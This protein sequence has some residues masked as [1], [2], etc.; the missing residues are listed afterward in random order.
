[1]DN[2]NNNAKEKKFQDALVD[3]K[4]FL[5][6]II[7]DFCQNL[8]EEEMEDHLGAKKYE[9]TY[10]RSGHRN[11][12]KPRMLKT[13]VGTL[14]LLVPQDRDGNFSTDL[15]N[16]Y[17]RSEKALV[18]TLM[19]MY[20]KGISTRK[21]ADVTEKLCGTSFSSSTIS[22]LAS[23]LDAKI[24][25]WNGRPLN[26]AYP[27][28]LVDT[29]YIKSRIED[30]V[31]AQ[32]AAVVAAIDSDGY[33]EILAVEMIDTETAQSYERIFKTLKARGLTGVKLVI[34]DDNRG[35]V[36]AVKK[37]FLGAFW[38]RC[39]F[40]FISNVVDLVPRKK[41]KYLAEDLKA[42][43]SCS[44]K[45]Q[46]LN[47]AKEVSKKYSKYSRIDE[48]LTC[49]ILD[50]LTFMDFPVEHRR[51][52]RTVNLIERLNSE[53]KRRTNVVR[54]FPNPESAKRLISAI[55]IEQNEEWISGRKYLNMDYLKN[56][57]LP[58]PKVNE[59][60]LVALT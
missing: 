20:V 3:E 60:S 18:L 8:L 47:L 25:A 35:L 51:R 46:A 30:S 17:Q 55:C 54:I 26:K 43:F 45:E 11:G 49:E 39:S 36:K 23:K 5:K 28:L 21:V 7:Q 34:S 1:M 37:H 38:Q 15:F 50:A 42:V 32:G 41:R 22:S 29:T 56:Y 44:S 52:I 31:L 2:Y 27:Y 16:R 58:E 53:I 4:D 19:E 33:R 48:M 59:S 9:R 14:N 6:N 57:K 13:R 12:Y 40:H 10:Q 24:S